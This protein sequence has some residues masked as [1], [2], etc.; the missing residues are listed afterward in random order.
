MK[1]IDKARVFFDKKITDRERA[2]FEG[3]IGLSAIFH[4]FIG[5]P[6]SNDIETIKLLEETI[7]KS[8][9]IQPFKKEVKVK[10]NVNKDLK[11]EEEYSYRSLEG[12]DF[13]VTVISEYG[14]SKVTS[15]MRYIPE[16]DYVLMYVEKIEE[17]PA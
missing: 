5:T 14:E 2:I 15:R 3:A 12:K 11:K 8:M 13:D 6:I 7:R 9:L 10:I 4:Q 1:T 17:R 16:M